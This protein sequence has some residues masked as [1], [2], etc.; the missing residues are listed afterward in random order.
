MNFS[1]L[2]LVSAVII[3]LA[4][5]SSAPQRSTQQTVKTP[6]GQKSEAT[7]SSDYHLDKAVEDY[8]RYGDIGQRNQW[9]LKAAESFQQ[10]Q[11]CDKSIKLLRVIQAE[12][13]IGLQQSQGQL[14]MAECYMQLAIPAVKQAQELIASISP[15]M[16]F[17]QRVN[18]LE[19]KIHVA[20]K[21]WLDAAKGVL[22]SALEY[23]DK[24]QK[25]W[26]FI[27]NLSLKE[28]RQARLDKSQLQP[29][30]QLSLITRQFGLQP[31]R[32]RTAVVEWQARHV[33]HPL[34]QSLPPELVS[35]LATDS[36]RAA[37]VAVLLPLT[38]RLANQGQAIKQGILAAY[39]DNLD[40]ATLPEP[41]LR[42]VVQGVVDN[43][44]QDT[45]RQIHFFDS[46]FSS[47]EELAELV[48][49]YD[50]VIGPLLKDKISG[51]LK[52]LP[53]D[54]P[55]LALNRVEQIPSTFTTQQREGFYFALAPED[56]AQQLAKY[57]SKIGLKH[58][59]VFAA[60]T[61]ATKRM[62]EAF[63]EQWKA[64][65][66][67]TKYIA[68]DI[69]T[70]NTNKE[71]GEQ[72]TALLDVANSKARIKQI[73]YLASADVF[74]VER[75]RRDIDAIV[76]FANPEQTELL[77]P[78]IETSLSPFA[79]QTLSVFASS[80]SYSL[81]LNKNSLRD[82]RNLTFSDM[83]WMLP[84]HQWG[85]LAQQTKLLWPQREDTLMRLF[86][87]GFDAYKLLPKLRH[88]K[89]LPHNT[90]AG[91]TGEISMDATGNLLRNLPWAKI[92]KDQVETL[93]MD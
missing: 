29:W 48:A 55:I 91:M 49:E 31:A 66:S 81:Q 67:N 62:T 82:L 69:A 63:A 20:N 65:A 87:L 19:V 23:S 56:E 70:F 4:S 8:S 57:I 85:N 14:I 17:E 68:P 10:E 54:K 83:P 43:L 5:C 9:L 74:G 22:A 25:I 73:E 21:Q 58:P 78:I 88:L 3:L 2:A 53:I 89:L 75:N 16:G 33:N 84:D 28:L 86:A 71:M 50:F 26:Q 76:L 13:Q 39:L 27:E 1:R 18:Q 42:N 52:E 61:N 11:K 7:F 32:L 35:A 15:N 72:V 90:V 47:P 59:I 45:T 93:A 60:N 34:S 6:S 80:R 77:N 44:P 51:L 12:L 79:R 36:F 46:A 37:K 24:S 64:S 92:R 40:E 38:G 41:S 30:I